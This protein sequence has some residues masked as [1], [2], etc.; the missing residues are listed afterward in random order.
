MDRATSDRSGAVYDIVDVL[1]P[2]S[3]GQ[4]PLFRRLARAIAGAVERGA[5][6]NGARLPSER[7]LAA[8]LAVGRGTAVAAYDILV[9]AG[10]IERRHGSGSYVR[11]DG[12]G[13]LPPGREG[14]ALVH[15]LVERGDHPSDVID[16]SISV[17][18]DAG[19]LPAASVSIGDLAS[20]TPETGYTPS[21]LPSLRRSIAAHISGW[22][23]P[24][25]EHQ[26][27][28]TTGAQQAISIAAACWVRPG[29]TVVVDDPTYPGALAAFRQ[30]GAVVVGAPM[31]GHGVQTATVRQRLGSRPA[32]L[33]LQSTLHSPTGMILGARRRR[34]IAELVAG[35]HVPLI[36]DLALTDLA[37][38]E[39]PPPI[40][41]LI[42]GASTAVVG[43]LSKLLWGGFRVGFVR[44]PE[45][46]ALRLARIK[47]THD[48]GS[49]AVS[50]LLVERLLRS[51]ALTDVSRQRT[52]Q[53]RTRHDVLATA[54]H[55]HL[56]AWRWREPSGGL[57]LWVRIPAPSSE[58]FAQYALRH[59]V[60]VAAPG[61]LS[62]SGNHRDR[63][64]LS[65]AAPPD[66][67]EE[68]VVRLAAAWRRM[69]G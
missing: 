37:W 21:G 14:T 59:G 52:E 5:V 36:E 55:R 69:P 58:P 16:L 20:V 39:A 31:D 7:A 4:G 1:G 32:A 11:L 57:S 35:S 15:R 30:A 29:D 46:L 18:R 13:L 34:E 44:A 54:L 28:I 23:L 67:L 27:V 25:D 51:V 2:W 42:P 40:A 8:T 26:V 41:A 19:G 47:A 66:E 62:P 68:G 12:S 9:A 64:R 63:L 45:A 22:G 49:S 61:V 33:Y 10:M 17:L 24:T 50:Q 56:P 48:L 43:S 38:S 65:F 60:A 53:L 3:E 6:A